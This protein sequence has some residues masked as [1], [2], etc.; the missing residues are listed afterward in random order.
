[1]R[2]VGE[3][4]PAAG[5]SQLRLPHPRGRALRRW[6]SRVHR[7]GAAP[8]LGCTL[9]VRAGY[10]EL[11]GQP[12]PLAARRR[13][14]LLMRWRAGVT[15]VVLALG[16]VARE[17]SATVDRPRPGPRPAG[18]R[19]FAR[20]F[21][22]LGVNQVSCGLSADGQICVDSTGSPFAGGGFWPRGTADQYVF[23]SGLEIA[24]IVGGSKA[25]NPWAGD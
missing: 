24:G 9:P 3:N 16:W 6:R 1:M 13:G 18:F 11:H 8:R 17:S 10:P 5:R 12:P 2:R 4:G 19:L 20:S 15:L 22:A 14:D 25:E 23:S 21:G 7:A